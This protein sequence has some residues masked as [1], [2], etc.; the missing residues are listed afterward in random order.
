MPR[1]V[2]RVC[3]KGWADITIY[4]PDGSVL[5]HHHVGNEIKNVGLDMVR[6][7]LSGAVASG[8]IR[9]LAW[10]SSADANSPGQTKLVAE[11]G[12]K[13]I[14][15]YSN[16]LT[17]ILYSTTY[18]GPTEATAHKVEELGWFA[19]VGA[20]DD[21]DTGILVGRLLYSREKTALEAWQ[22]VRSDI[23]A[24]VVP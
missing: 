20:T 19:G 13:A 14:T 11:F 23:L 8:Q 15:T 24:E 9:Y 7:L 16:G 3:W 1:V 21:P 5:Q 4:G 17:G 12:R 2:E 22:V 18:I 6:D 10:G